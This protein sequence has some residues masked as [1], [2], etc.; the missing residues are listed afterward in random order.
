M[1]DISTIISAIAAVAS[2]MV[3]VGEFVLHYQERKRRLDAIINDHELSE[4]E[5]EEDDNAVNQRDNG[6]YAINGKGR[7]PKNRMVLEVIRKYVSTHSDVTFSELRKV[8]PNSAHGTKRAET[9]WG[10]FNLEDDARK[11]FNDT[12]HARHFL[13]DDEL[14]TL[15]DGS[16]IAVSTQW[17]ISNIQ[18]FID[19]AQNL[20]YKITRI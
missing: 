10:C 18:C 19:I 11:L 16:R 8:F 15:S 4:S 5:S 17:G 2:S 3:A 7:Y 20:G 9:F 12:G 6:R 14:I 13:K 1:N